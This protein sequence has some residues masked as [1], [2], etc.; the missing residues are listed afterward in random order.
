M[1]RVLR[2]LQLAVQ[3]YE[4]PAMLELARR[5]LVHLSSFFFCE[6]RNQRYLE[7]PSKLALE[8]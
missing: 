1:L 8:F 4:L 5:R 2:F 6:K 3:E 7:L